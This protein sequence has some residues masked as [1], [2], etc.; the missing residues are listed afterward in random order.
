MTTTT[1]IR[2]RV[3]RTVTC[4]DGDT[5]EEWTPQAS[6]DGSVWHATTGAENCSTYIDCSDR[7]AQLGAELSS[8]GV[9]VR[10]LPSVTIK[11]HQH[12]GEFGTGEPRP[13]RCDSLDA[14]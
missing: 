8:A 9:D 11:R 7:C 1:T 13:F 4:L 10:H 2:L 12:I 5:R 3:A 6:I 14:Y